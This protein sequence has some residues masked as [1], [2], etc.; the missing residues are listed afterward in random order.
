MNKITIE[1]DGW[2]WI[3]FD[4]NDRTGNSDVKKRGLGDIGVDVEIVDLR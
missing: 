4:E 1:K 3:E 2:V